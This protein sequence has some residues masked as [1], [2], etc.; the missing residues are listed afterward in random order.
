MWGWNDR[1]CGSSLTESNLGFGELYSL[2]QGSLYNRG[3]PAKGLIEI[4]NFNALLG[5][6]H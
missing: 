4:T 1:D 5:M 6:K 3:F 2:V